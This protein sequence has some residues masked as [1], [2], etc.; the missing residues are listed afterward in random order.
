MIRVEH[1]KAAGQSKPVKPAPSKKPETEPR[2]PK[3]EPKTVDGDL[4]MVE[5]LWKHGPAP[6]P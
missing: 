1:A 3:E 5:P 2:T 6:K 4:L